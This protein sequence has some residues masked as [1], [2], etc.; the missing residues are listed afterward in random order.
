MRL[1]YYQR[2]DQ[3]SN[4]GDQ[5]NPWLWRKLLP[6]VFD[7]A[8]STV[9]VGI[10]TLLNSALPERV[11]QAEQVNIFSTG[12]G[13][14]KPLKQV[15]PSWRIY[16]VRGPLSAQKLGLPKRI[17]IADGGIL[18]RRFF[19]PSP[20]KL[21]KFAFM[22][23]IHH[24][25]CAGLVW[26]H[27][28]SQ[29]DI[30]YIDPSWS[31]EQ[32]LA[33]I[34]QTETLLA[35]AMHGAIAADALRT[36]WIPIVTSGRILG[37]KWL[38]WCASVGLKYRPQYLKPLTSIYPRLTSGTQSST[39]AA[40]HWSRCIRQQPIEAL[41]HLGKDEQQ[42]ALYQL[43]HIMRNTRPNLS[44]EEKLEQLTLALEERLQQLVKDLNLMK[45]VSNHSS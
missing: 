45:G 10:G 26:R 6:G 44:K 13:Y 19:T 3:L 17:G 28:C 5:L 14:E 41:A 18:L 20:Q 32:V 1:I 12:V 33:A 22:P 25:K 37:F 39:R 2:R 30:G 40:R 7:Q 36:P 27:L 24:A 16:C 21:T 38:D 34:G 29:L 8:S 23:H 43:R 15:S 35:E 31:I 42:Q 4:F 9:F 11:A